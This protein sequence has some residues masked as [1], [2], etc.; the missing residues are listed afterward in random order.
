MFESLE[1]FVRGMKTKSSLNI[2]AYRDRIP[3]NN[4]PRSGMWLIMAEIDDELEQCIIIIGS[5]NRHIYMVKDWT[6]NGGD[7]SNSWFDNRLPTKD[8]ENWL[9]ENDVF[10]MDQMIIIDVHKSPSW[11]NIK[12]VNKDEQRKNIAL[13]RP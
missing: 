10:N 4:L 13:R 3:W 12:Q 1:N 6:G 7:W 2:G 11:S 8:L 5:G 9:K